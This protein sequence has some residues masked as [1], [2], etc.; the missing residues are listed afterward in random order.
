M[1]TLALLLVALSCVA[2][3]G[4]VTQP[5]FTHT[6]AFQSSTSSVSMPMAKD[7]YWEDEFPPSEILGPIMS[8]MPS[9]VL[10]VLSIVFLSTCA[11]SCF[12]SGILQQED[13]A[14]SRYVR[15]YL[16]IQFSQLLDCSGSWVK[17]YYVLGS[18][19]GPL[20][21]GTHVACWIQRKNGM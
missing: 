9:S 11:F 13:G 8:K 18:F 1:K 2:V 20:A 10:G 4:F 17:W 16:Y 21:W 15:C 6:S 5:T 12:Q 7:T 14:L 3:Q 19:G